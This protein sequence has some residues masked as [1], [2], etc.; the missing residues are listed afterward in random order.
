[1]I[2]YVMLII[3]T[4]LFASCT[5]TIQPVAP[6][7]PPKVVIAHHHPSKPK[8]L[9]VVSKGAMV[10]SNWIS[11]YKKL[12]DEHGHYTITEDKWVK[13]TE[14]GRFWIPNAVLEHYGDLS[15]T[16]SPTP[17]PAETPKP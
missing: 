14:S 9:G 16:A 5:I 8:P 17:P 4:I 2:Q 15:R 10:D 12:E 7:E 3:I 1:M 6:I 13:P 11:D